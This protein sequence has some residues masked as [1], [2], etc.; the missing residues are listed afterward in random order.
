VDALNVFLA[1][2]NAKRRHYIS[3]QFHFNQPHSTFPT[4]LPLAKLQRV[5]QALLL[6]AN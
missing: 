6:M 5:K 4:A 2:N 1:V 3:H